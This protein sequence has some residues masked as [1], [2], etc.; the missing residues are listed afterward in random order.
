MALPVE[1]SREAEITYINVIASIGEKWTEREVEQFINRTERVLGYISER[2]AMYPF[3]KKGLLHRAVISKHTSL[4]YE[5]TN[6]K[7]V[8][9]SFEDN[10]QDPAK[11]KY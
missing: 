6:Q 8:L 10:R 7:I 1:W 4:Y 2:P 9:L 3:S 11:I 5:S